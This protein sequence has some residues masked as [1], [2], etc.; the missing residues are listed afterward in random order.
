MKS[1]EYLYNIKPEELDGL[2]YWAGLK[3]KIDSATKLFAL[4][5]TSA[6]DTDRLFYVNKAIIHTRKLINERDEE[7]HTMQEEKNE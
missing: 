5:Y 2:E 3:L 6:Q 4:L 7:M 1:T